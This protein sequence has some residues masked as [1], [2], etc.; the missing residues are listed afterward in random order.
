MWCDGW[1]ARYSSLLNTDS[2]YLAVAY[3]HDLHFVVGFG[4]DDNIKN[5]NLGGYVYVLT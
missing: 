4:D 3:L 5:S 2:I 1:K